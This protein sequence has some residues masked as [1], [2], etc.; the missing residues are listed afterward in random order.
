MTG[1]FLAI[2]ATFLGG[3]KSGFENLIGNLIG[4]F[5]TCKAFFKYH[6]MGHWSGSYNEQP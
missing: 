3:G 2:F 6:D 5:K 4:I 1:T